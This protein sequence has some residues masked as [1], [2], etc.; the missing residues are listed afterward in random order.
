M[1]DE[2]ELI[3]EELVRSAACNP[4]ISIGFRKKVLRAARKAQRQTT[5]RRRIRYSAGLVI[6][7]LL[8]SA[9]VV[10]LRTGRSA[11]GTPTPERST[12]QPPPGRGE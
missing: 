6:L 4:P 7:V 11:K 9:C 10:A 12:R 5:L 8:F 3:A 1:V 2:R